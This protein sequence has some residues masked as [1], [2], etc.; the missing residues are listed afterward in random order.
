[1]NQLTKVASRM[2]S[3][4][5]I[6]F[7]TQV[8]IPILYKNFKV[9]GGYRLDF[10]IENSVIVELKVVERILPLHEAQR[11]TYLKI[12]NKPVGL[13]LNFNSEVMKDGIKRLIL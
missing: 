9:N 1:M 10:L 13:L 7:K 3:L 4:Q 6:E 2:I 5:K 12:T 11:L 8:E